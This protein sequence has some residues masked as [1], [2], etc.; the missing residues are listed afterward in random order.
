MARIPKKVSERLS[1]QVQRFQK[2]LQTAKNRDVNE[3]DTVTIITDMLDG[4]FGYDK[5]TEVT[6]EQAI[7]GTYCDLAVK[8]D[9]QVK[10]LIEVKAI[11]LSLKE[12]HLRQAVNYAANLGTS[13]IVL[14]N[15]VDWE[16]YKIRFDRPIS[17]DLVCSFNFLELNGRKQDNQAQLF[18]LCREGMTKDAIN[19]FHQRVQIVNRFVMGALLQSDSVI[20][21]LRRELRRIDPG[22]KADKEE[23]RSILEDVLKR[24]VIEGEAASKAKSRIQRASS[25][26]LRKRKSKKAV[27][28]PPPNSGS[29]DTTVEVAEASKRNELS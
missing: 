3:S 12:T 10:Y 29:S 25:R 27:A 21:V 6:S 13:W 19:E 17:H 2:V 18:I 24:D 20:D 11:G 28:T 23:L 22:V 9:D 8:L 1:K 26:A 5:Y 4:V 15:A 14:T 7:R 16:I